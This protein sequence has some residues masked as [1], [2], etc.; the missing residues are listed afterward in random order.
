[1]LVDKLLKHPGFADRWTVFFA[2]QFRIRANAD[3]GAA[4]LAFV[5][6]AVEEGVPYDVLCRQ[7]LTASGKAG[8]VPEVGF[9]LGDNADPMAL[10]GTAAQVFMGTRIACAQCHDHPFDVWTREQFYGM[11]AFFGKTARRESEFTNSVYAYEM[12]STRV[13]WPPEGLA[14][15]A[16]RKA[17]IPK[18]PF[19]LDLQGPAPEAEVRLVALRKA[20]EDAR[21]A[22][23]A[24]K[25]SSIDELLNTA[26]KKADGG[27][28]KPDTLDVA[29]ASRQQVKDLNVEGDLYKL[30]EQRMDLADFITSP[31]NKLFSQSFVN[32]VWAD[33]MGR[34]FV[35]PV[36][37]FGVNNPPSHDKTLAFLADE[38]VAGGYDLRKLVKMIVLTDAYSRGHVYEPDLQKRQAVEH[39]F[40]AVPVRRM[41][42]ETMF[43]SVVSAGHLF[44][45][46][47]AAGDNLKTIKEIVQ[48]AVELEGKP[49]GGSVIS[50][51][52][53]GA[54]A[55]MGGAMNAMAAGES[56]GGSG[57]DLETAI[58]VDFN[59]V[60]AMAKKDDEPKV[61]MMQISME[62]QEARM[63]AEQQ[64]RR[65]KFVD[66]VVEKVIDDNPV[67]ASA[68]RM[69]SPA[70]PAHFLRIFGQPARD[71]LGDHRDHSASMRQALMMLNG[72]M[73]HEA[74]RVG[75]LEPLY[76]LLTGKTADTDA[77]IKLA[78]REI[79][80]RA[81]SAEE[82]ADARTMLTEAASPIDGMADLRWI[83]F[84]CHEFRFIP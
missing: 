4:E 36:D 51:V 61:E 21:R 54:G 46:K 48:V 74:S 58:E 13:K 23:E 12:S 20:E 78:Y 71:Q 14:P 28:K 50:Q 32:R 52:Q 18:F 3:G 81:P 56:S 27:F 66:K 7:L 34:G 43:D 15:E 17:M 57:Y 76:P 69:P 9:V 38:F 24:A 29:A 31:R 41:L 47:H 35:E 10:A 59:Q 30:S 77:A 70:P 73:T 62:D 64:G 2:D 39:A 5:H 68:M 84:N 65:R 40:A 83:L 16:E 11:A 33:L 45:Q 75:K 55:A 79:L 8:R 37:D 80:T 26:A 60:L 63:L 67:F 72:K 44:S 42:A 49:T 1:M 6:K 53:N 22:A 25:H 19:D 82:L